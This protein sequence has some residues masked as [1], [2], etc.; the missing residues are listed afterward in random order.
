MAKIISSIIVKRKIHFRPFSNYYLT[1]FNIHKKYIAS[2]ISFHKFYT[3]K[4][5]NE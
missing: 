3:I 4:D 2:S 1:M 5:K